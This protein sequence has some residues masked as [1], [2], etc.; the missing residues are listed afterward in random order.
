MK[1]LTVY[2]AFPEMRF[3]SNGLISLLEEIWQLRAIWCGLWVL[4]KSTVCFELL[5]HL[6]RPQIFV[7]LLVC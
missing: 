3:E 4:R 6:S 2:Y 5:I 1:N 7:Y